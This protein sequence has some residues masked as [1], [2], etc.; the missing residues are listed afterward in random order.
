M[1]KNLLL[2]QNSLKSITV[3][4]RLTQIV[5][6]ISLNEN[7]VSPGFSKIIGVQS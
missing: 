6:S 1:I 5:E 3:P 2:F 4:T 7:P